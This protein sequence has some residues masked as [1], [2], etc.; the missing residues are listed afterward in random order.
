MLLVQRCA[1]GGGEWAAGPE[2]WRQLREKPEDKLT[3]R[4]SYMPLSSNADHSQTEPFC[5]MRPLGPPSEPLTLKTVGLTPS[6]PRLF[7][8]LDDSDSLV[9]SV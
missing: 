6:A 8:C 3:V 7:Q 1:A 5:L 2:P 4:I 9:S